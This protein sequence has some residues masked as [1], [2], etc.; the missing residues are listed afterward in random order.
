MALV[1]RRRGTVARYVRE[2]VYG[3]DPIGAADVAQLHMLTYGPLVGG[4]LGGPPHFGMKGDPSMTFSGLVASPQQFIGQAQM[5]KTS[6]ISVQAYPALPNSSPPPANRQWLQ[7][8]TQEEE[9][10]A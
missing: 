7:D 6:A 2:L 10:L 3:P 5:G 9:L 4:R 8:W 1:A